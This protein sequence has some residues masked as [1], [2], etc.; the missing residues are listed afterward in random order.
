MGRLELSR[1]Y[2]QSSDDSRGYK[3]D[4]LLGGR[5]TKHGGGEPHCHCPVVQ[6]IADVPLLPASRAMKAILAFLKDGR[7]SQR[8]SVLS[9]VLIMTAFIAVISG[10]LMTELTTNFLVSNTLLNRV[11]NEATVNSAIELSLSQLQTTQLNAS[12]P[13]LPTATVNNLSASATYS[14]CWPTIREAQKFIR[15]GASS[16]SFGLDGTQAQA[17]GF[18]DY[19]VGNSSGLVFDYRF[20]ASAPRWTYQLNGTLTASPLVI[21]NPSSG[22]QLLDIFPMTGAAC[23][24]DTNCMVVR[25]DNNSSSTSQQC[26]IPA[27]SGAV[28]SQPEASPGF[29]GFVYYGD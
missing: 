13:V 27:S 1:S 19:V 7:R 4:G 25:S 6:R 18:N 10:A 23:S 16:A 24:P 26:I 12:C 11:A 28:V 15:V 5:P 2:E 17:N 20:G 3:R 29:P 22:N 14:S 8:G 9:G 21:G